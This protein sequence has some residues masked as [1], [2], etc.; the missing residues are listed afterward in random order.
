[1]L[2]TEQWLALKDIPSLEVAR[3]VT[4]PSRMPVLVDFTAEEIWAAIQARQQ[5]GGAND[6]GEPD[7]K[8]VEWDVLTQEPP[9]A[10]TKD[11]RISRV[12]AP[13]GF[14][15]FFEPMVL[16]ELVREVRALLAFTRIESKGDFTDADYEDD[17]RQT[18]LSRQSPTW[19]PASEVRGEG[20]FLRLNETALQAWEQKPGT[21]KLEQEFLTLILPGGGCG[22]CSHPGTGSPG[23]VLFCC[24]P[25]PTP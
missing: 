18:A 13:N 5:G 21:K 6:E 14:G 2:V 15:Q 7:L 19:L 11:F 12:P 9:P 10:P 1:M 8:T 4:A 17:G 25:C 16:V 20:I 3:F 22:S 24:I 23:F